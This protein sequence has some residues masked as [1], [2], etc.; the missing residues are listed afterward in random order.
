MHVSP[1]LVLL[2]GL[3]TGLSLTVFVC[4]LPVFRR[5]TLGDRLAPYLRDRAGPGAPRQQVVPTGEGTGGVTAAAR[6]TVLRLADWLSARLT[7]TTG[8]AARL[9][10]TGGKET[11]ERFRVWQVLCISSGLAAGAGLSVLVAFSRGFNPVVA[12]LLVGI[13]GVAGHLFND[14]RLSTVVRRRER[15]ILEEFPTVAELLALSVTAGESTVDALERV[16]RT[17]QGELGHELETAL[18]A[19]RTGTPLVQALDGMAR[20]S[21]VPGIVRFV[22]GVAVAIARGTPLAEVLR[23]QAADVRTEGR[24][25]LMEM[26]G[27]KEI[28]ML[29]PVV[30]FVLPITVLFAVYP[31]LAVLDLTP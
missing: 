21:G 31:S 6:R 17:T 16:S 20:R 26:S 4:A 25:R 23:A 29:V 14:W 1:L 3:A 19:A 12:L 18:A 22:D 13:G 9:A 5:P 11:V 2:S 15:L 10:R 8:V 30:A 27:R 28:L 7:T 24:R